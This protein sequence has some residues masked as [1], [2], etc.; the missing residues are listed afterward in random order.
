MTEYDYSPEAVQQYL[1]SQMRIQQWTAVTARSSPVDPSTPPTPALRPSVGLPPIQNSSTQTAWAHKKQDAM[2]KMHAYASA[3][4]PNLTVQT[5]AAAGNQVYAYAQQTTPYGSQLSITQQT[6]DGRYVQ[7]QSYRETTRPLHPTPAP[8]AQMLEVPPV[9]YA[10]L[11]QNPHPVP[12][13]FYHSLPRAAGAPTRTQRVRSKSSHGAHPAP[14]PS[15][16]MCISAL[17]V[18]PMPGSERPRVHS[19]VRPPGAAA[20]FN[21]ANPIYVNGLYGGPSTAAVSSLH[22]PTAYL[23][24]QHASQRPLPRH[25]QVEV[26]V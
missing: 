14:A 5:P 16:G 1:N 24:P 12:E 3:A 9:N 2:R 25:G 10:P 20:P 19:S 17:P 11:A 21:P 6:S 22:L 13:H 8:A 23:A 18:P 7:Q 26:E 4:P 15:G